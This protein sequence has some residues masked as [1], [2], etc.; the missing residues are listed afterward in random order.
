MGSFDTDISVQTSVDMYKQ[1]TLTDGCRRRKYIGTAQV[2]DK[3][4]I[5]RLSRKDYI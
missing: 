4:V 3:V 2:P 1:P 5:Q